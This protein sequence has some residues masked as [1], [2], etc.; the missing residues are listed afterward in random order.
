MSRVVYRGVKGTVSVSETHVTWTPDGAEHH[1]PLFA[2]ADVL[3]VDDTVVPR[4]RVVALGKRPTVITFLDEDETACFGRA[5]Y[6]R[7]GVL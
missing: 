5:L 6:T 2:L 3:Y 4:L 7:L 1:R